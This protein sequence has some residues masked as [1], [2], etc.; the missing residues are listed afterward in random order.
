MWTWRSALGLVGATLALAEAPSGLALGLAGDPPDPETGYVN[1]D[2]R[3]T[4]A[5]IRYRGAENWRREPPWAHDYPIADRH[6]MRILQDLTTVDPHTEG[7]NLFTL[8]DPELF[9]FPVA[10]MSEPGFWTLDEREAAG[11]RNYLLKGGF[12]IF[13]DFRS[14]DLQRFQ[15]QLARALPGAQLIELDGSHPVFHS[16]FEVNPLEFVQMYDVGKPIFYGVFEDN[17][18]DGRLMLVANYNNDLGE[19]WE[20]SATGFVPVALSNEAY[21]YGVNYYIY[22]LT[23]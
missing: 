15:T 11:L 18:P 1:Y 6:L 21:K 2:G 3:V 5:R 13:D 23:H 7:S 22:G 4:F 8:D 10:Y 12:M 14:F 17:D 20:F 16:F 9:N 19:Y